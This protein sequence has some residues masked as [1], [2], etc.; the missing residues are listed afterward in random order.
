M[1]TAKRAREEGFCKRHRRQPRRG[2]RTSTRS[3]ASR[4][5][6]TRPSARSSGPIWIKIN[7]PLDTVKVGYLVAP[8][9]AGAAGEG[10]P[11]LLPDRQP[12]GPG[13][14]R[15]QH[16]RPDRRH[17]GHEDRRLHR[18][19][20]PG[21]RRP[22]APGLPRHRLQEVGADGRR[23]ASSSPA[24]TASSRT[25]ARPRS[26]SWPRRRRSSPSRRGIPR[27]SPRRWSTRR[28]RS[29]RRKDSA[30]RGRQALAPR[31][32]SRPTAAGYQVDPASARRPAISPDRHGRRGRLLRAGPGGR[33]RRGAQGP[34]WPAG[35]G[36][37]AST[38]RAGSTRW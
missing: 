5:S 23:P 14:G 21:R 37:S 30:D 3:A 15:R 22:L 4:R 36:R 9:R 26:R 34:L 20:R 19:P 13:F 24:G 29:S 12:R 16:R 33:E 2:R 38:A 10:Q 25:S 8:D 6:R 27:P 7:G 32:R 11:G 35:Q 31:A 1:L 28:P 17:Q 18:R